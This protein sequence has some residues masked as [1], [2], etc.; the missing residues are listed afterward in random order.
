MK[1]N[2]TVKFLSTI[3]ALL[4]MNG[5]VVAQSTQQEY[6]YG[7]PQTE[8]VKSSINQD[9]RFHLGDADADYY[10]TNTNDKQWERVSV[11]HTLSLTSLGLNGVQDSKMQETFQREVGW[12][13]RDIEVSKSDKLVYLEFEGVHQITTLWVNGKE[14]GTHR[15]GGYTPFEFDITP[16]V[17]RGAVNQITVMADNRSS[18]VTPPDPG[19][20]DYIK[21]SGLYRDVYLVEKSKMHITSN[22]ES[23]NS[24]VTITTPTVDYVNGNA[25]IDIRT[26][27]RNSGKSAQR[28][29]LV[30][31]VVD[32]DGRVVLKLEQS[33]MIAAGQTHRFYQVGG[34]DDDIKL[35]DIDNPYLYTVNTLL[36]DGSG[37]EID[38]VDNPLGLRVFELDHQRGFILN[39][40]VIELI[41]FNRHQHYAYI[42]DA[43]PNS[44]HY[45][46]M[47]QFKQWGFNV[48]R[49]AHYPQDDEI[50]R[51][52]DK[53]GILVYEEAPT[54][55]SISDE[56]EWYENEMSAASAMIRNH[57]NH[58]SVV[59]WGGGINH[60]GAVP[61]IQFVTKMED[62]TRLTSS[63]SSRWTGAQHS[64]WTD[65]FG[66]MNYGPGIW[67]RNEAL[68]AMEG[69]DGPAVVAQYKLDPMMPGIISWTAH[70]YYTFHDF[71]GGPDDKTRLGAMDSYRYPKSSELFWYPSEMKQKPYIHMVDDWS[72][73]NSLYTIYS[74]ATYIELINNGRNLGRF[75][76]SKSTVYQGLDHAPF[77]ISSLPYQDGELEIVGYRDGEVM[78][79]KSYYTPQSA[80]ALRLV[81]DKYDVD[82]VADENDILVVHAEVVDANGMIIKDYQGEVKFTVDGDASVVGDDAE[83]GANPVAVARGKGSAL[84]RSGATAGK[85]TIS[86]SADGLK[87]D[88][89]TV[90]T[91]DNATDMMLAN[92][93]PI[94]D[95]QTLLVDIGGEGQLLQ[96]GWTKWVGS[97][98]SSSISIVPTTLKN[99]VA[100]NTPACENVAEVVDSATPGAYQFT[101]STVSGSGVLRW[102]GEMN[103]IGR[104]GYVYGDG[105]LSIDSDGLLL[106][107]ENLPAGDYTL[108]GYH[109]APRSNTN[110]MDPNLERLK[111]E[112]IPN[113]PYAKVLSVSVDGVE[114][115]SSLRITQGAEMNSAP[116]ATSDVI[117]TVDSEDDK[118]S[119]IYKSVDGINGVWLN[120]FELER[121]L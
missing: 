107:I 26:E 61:Q 57:K 120:G 11:P 119:I 46:D 36:K 102:L 38:V 58:P 13:R 6:P 93:Y 33:A 44:L 49:T 76:P 42:G 3:V 1:T 74:N 39:G 51:A 109:H 78:L 121:A 69:N 108:R 9:W 7:Y 24:G 89:A 100:G 4:A 103:V 27:V 19:P 86:A 54:W 114:Q 21:F 106:E 43:M 53:L 25:T 77:E 66:N 68:F 111:S 99:F 96:F 63:Q 45:K 2:R 81:V 116:V 15:T 95:H 40:K 117:F 98:D 87:G 17:R 55:I 34:I 31:R 29:T 47:L 104:I 80:S 48:M 64:S 83:I 56:Q 101:L 41:G 12:Y 110:D 35:W 8:R 18:L 84:I 79:S 60:R 85:I 70:A 82:F 10:K 72:A 59:I 30:Q 118:I 37:N 88:S 28:A 5:V 75:Y 92:A 94:F 112:S 113:L 50:L 90:E 32:A 67:N 73:E 16:Y 105:V 115:I 52:C 97:E 71:G 20:F 23:L 62:P 65:I 14:V 91:V 22:I